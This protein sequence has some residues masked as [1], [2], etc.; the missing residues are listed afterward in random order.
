MFYLR[1]LLIVTWTCLLISCAPTRYLEGSQSNQSHQSGVNQG[2]HLSP[3]ATALGEGGHVKR[4]KPYTVAGKTYYPLAS[5][6]QYNQ[7]GIASWYG[8]KFHGKKTA[9]GETY[10]M[11]A[12]TAAH[13]T[14]P[15]PAVVLVTNLDNGKSVKVR[16]NDRGPFVKNRLI[17]LSYSAAKA[18]GYAERG[19]AHVRVQTLD[20]AAPHVPTIKHEPVQQNVAP[21]VAVVPTPVVIPTPAPEKPQGNPEFAYIQ[22]GAFSAKE[23]A[24]GVVQSLKKSLKQAHPPVHIV[25]VNDIYRVRVGPFDL[26]EDAQAALK[27]IQMDGF[28]AAVVVHD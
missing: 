20:T 14:L 2:I 10:N 7:T 8:K 17:D 23:N 26:D 11:Y 25:A 24:D 1:W 15:M 6:A 18:L 12:M 9:N 13:T 27:D 4:G 19:T 16:V 21:P 3:E 22:V 28:S 5:S